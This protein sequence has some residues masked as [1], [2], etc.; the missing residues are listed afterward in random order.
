MSNISTSQQTSL[1]ILRDPSRACFSKH[2]DLLE[3]E[4]AALSQLH[5]LA[6]VVALIERERASAVQKEMLR[7]A[8]KTVTLCGIHEICKE[9]NSD[10][11]DL[12]YYKIA[13]LRRGSCLFNC[14]AEPVCQKDIKIE[15]QLSCEMRGGSMDGFTAQ[16]SRVSMSVKD[17]ALV[18]ILISEYGNK[19]KWIDRL[20]SVKARACSSLD[21]GFDNLDG[22]VA[23][24]LEGVSFRI[25]GRILKVLDLQN[26]PVAYLEYSVGEL[27]ETCIHVPIDESSEYGARCFWPTWLPVV[28]DELTIQLE[29]YYRENLS[30]EIDLEVIEQ[31]PNA[32]KMIRG[33][34]QEFQHIGLYI[35]VE[36]LTNMEIFTAPMFHDVRFD[37]SSKKYL[38]SYFRA[39]EHLDSEGLARLLLRI[40]EMAE[41]STSGISAKNRP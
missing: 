15:F 18:A 13:K 23:I 39:S 24:Y 36:E 11:W 6:R 38:P 14:F 32:A 40:K 12:T 25:D 16:N 29:T 4:D 8:I 2:L 34:C 26:I 30:S 22:F 31:I 17:L 41:L 9:E 5:P 10:D 35:D 21:P 3:Q 33:W 1:N 28:A 20:L 7:Q 37:I 27:V 19:Q